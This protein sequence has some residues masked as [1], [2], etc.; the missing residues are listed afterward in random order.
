MEKKCS[1]II[2]DDDKDDQEFLIK[3]IKQAGINCEIESAYDGEELMMMLKEKS[4][5][6]NEKLPDLIVLDLNMPLM[7][8]YEVLKELK[9]SSELKHIPVY[10]LTTSE[11]EFDKIKSIAYGARKFYSKPLIYTDLVKIVQDMFSSELQLC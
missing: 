7:D 3:A 11:F 9:G 10:I 6:Q 8:G 1:V 5:K 4:G 2:T